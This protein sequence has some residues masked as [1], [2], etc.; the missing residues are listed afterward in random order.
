[1][2]FD[3][4]LRAGVTTSVVHVVA[5]FLVLADLR[6]CLASAWVLCGFVPR[7]CVRVCVSCALVS[8]VFGCVVCVVCVC[9]CLCVVLRVCR[10][11]RLFC[12]A[13]CSPMRV[14]NIAFKWM[15]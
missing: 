2:I 4:P 6:V 12:T 8:L 1:M 9:V 7:V 3:L 5:A 11:R 13:V 14:V 10:A 15:L